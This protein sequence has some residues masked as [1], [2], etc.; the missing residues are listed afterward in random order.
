MLLTP[1]YQATLSRLP[2]DEDVALEFDQGN[3]LWQET[4]EEEGVWGDDTIDE[5]S[6]IHDDTAVDDVV[7]Q[8]FGDVRRFSLLSTAEEQA[9]WR[10]IER[11]KARL[12]HALI[13][14]P[15]ALPTLTEMWQQLE[16]DDIGLQQVFD[17]DATADQKELRTRFARVLSQLQELAGRLQLLAAAGQTQRTLRQKGVGLWRQWIALCDALPFHRQVYERLQEALERAQRAIPDDAAVHAAQTGWERAHAALVE[18]KEQMLRAN[19][20]LVIYVANRYR[21]RG[22]PLLDLVQEG[23]IGLMRALEK[24]EPSRGFKFVTYAHWWVRQ[25]ISRALVEQQ[26][27]VRLPNHVVERQ[28]KLRATYN[29][30]WDV[31]GRAPSVQEISLALQWTPQEVEDLTA[32]GQP[33]VRLYKPLT[34]DGGV[35]AD[36]LE[37]VHASRPEELVAEDQLQCRLAQCLASLPEREALILR[38]RYGLETGHAHTLQEIG[39][40]LGVSRERIRQLEK[41]ALDKLRQPQRSALLADFADVA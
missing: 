39:E 25:A 36:I 7:A 31:H 10:R 26:R 21:N 24:F 37:D 27:T 2:E 30:L 1:D 16:R 20:R 9:L 17:A 13:T 35:L 3:D 14:S 28:N 6:P 4:Q 8:Y 41:L 34:E 12:R 29:R 33:I 23:N 18:A 40:R 32:V 15:V 5:T 22:M 38:L 19:L 11:C